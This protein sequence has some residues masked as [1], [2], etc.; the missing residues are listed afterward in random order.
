MTGRASQRKGSR[1]E[2]ELAA[3][4]S[5]LLGVECRKGSSPF[6]PGIVAPDV[7]GLPGI[8]CETKRR[9][10]FSIPAAM[11]QAAADARR[12]D[13]AIVAHRPNRHG[14]MLT[15]RLTDLPRLAAAVM[16]ITANRTEAN[17]V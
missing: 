12:G 14:W 1:A 3:I 13:V 11:N 4:L 8:H 2:R 15:V 10:R 6:L 9:E 7:I 17:H 16:A 5:G